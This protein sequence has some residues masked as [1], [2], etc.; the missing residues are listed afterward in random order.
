MILGVLLIFLMLVAPGGL[1]GVFKSTKA[2]M[3]I[4][5]AAKAASANAAA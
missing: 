3:T 2:K 1:V 4:R 5:K